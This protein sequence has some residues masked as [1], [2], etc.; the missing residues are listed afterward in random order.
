MTNFVVNGEILN[1]IFGK[2]VEHPYTGH[3]TS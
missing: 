3:C 1:H 2:P